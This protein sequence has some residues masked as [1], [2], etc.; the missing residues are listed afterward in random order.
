MSFTDTIRTS[1]AARRR[2]HIQMKRSIEKHCALLPEPKAITFSLPFW[3]CT[4]RLRRCQIFL[5]ILAR[6]QRR[7]DGRSWEQGRRRECADT[8]ASGDGRCIGVRGSGAACRGGSG[9]AAAFSAVQVGP[10]AEGA[11][12]KRGWRGGAN[13]HTHVHKHCHPMDARA[14]THSPAHAHARWVHTS[15][16]HTTDEHAH[17]IV[18]T[19]EGG[20]A[21]GDCHTLSSRS[22]AHEHLLAVGFRV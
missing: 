1:S 2:V 11:G 19:L 18:G 4:Y 17:T 14:R 8:G 20:Q 5:K 15:R 10:G 6:P 16:V 22:L 9:S 21:S 7:R 13:L 12:P 3:R